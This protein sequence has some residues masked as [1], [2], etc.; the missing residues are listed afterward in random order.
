LSR[1]SGSPYMAEYKAPLAAIWSGQPIN[2]GPYM[3]NST[4]VA[5]LGQL[6]RPLHA[7]PY[8]RLR[9]VRPRDGGGRRVLSAVAA[10]RN[11]ADLSC[12]G[13]HQVGKFCR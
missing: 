1:L 8:L 7:A 12:V 6:A 2:S 10:R 5:V 9:P 11:S 13:R 3:V 4:M